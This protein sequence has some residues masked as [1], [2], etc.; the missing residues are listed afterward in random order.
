MQ[1]AIALF[2]QQLAHQRAP[3]QLRLLPVLRGFTS[4]VEAPSLTRQGLLAAFQSPQGRTQDQ[5]SASCQPVLLPQ[6][7]REGPSRQQRSATYDSGSHRRP[8][9]SDAAEEYNSPALDEAMRVGPREW[10]ETEQAE[11]DRWLAEEG[12]LEPELRTPTREEVDEQLE[13]LFESHDDDDEGEPEY[14]GIFN[15]AGNNQPAWEVV[16]VDD[17]ICASYWHW[18]LIGG[19]VFENEKNA[20]LSDEA[21]KVIYFL[22]K[23]AGCVASYAPHSSALSIS[24]AGSGSELLLMGRLRTRAARSC[25]NTGCQPIM[26]ISTNS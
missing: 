20:L 11:I 17:E 14:D 19:Q 9:S 21:K 12:S 8:A 26:S 16:D 15:T 22:H 2:A 1:R 3:E 23:H 18:D 6:S 24:P 25:R 10:T 7:V 13:G 4:L 5:R